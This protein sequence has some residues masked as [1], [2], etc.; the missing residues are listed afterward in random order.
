MGVVFTTAVN[1]YD[2]VSDY[3]IHSS[4]FTRSHMPFALFLG[5]LFLVVLVNPLLK[6]R[7]PGAVFTPEDLAVALTIGFLGMSV[8]TMVGRFM[9]TVSAP[10]YSAPRRTSGPHTCCRT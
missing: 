8:P 7:W 6:W 3:I 2:P 5:L 9:G 1:I 10:E 4:S